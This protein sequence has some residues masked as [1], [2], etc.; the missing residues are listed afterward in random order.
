MTTSEATS[1]RPAPE[2]K[3]TS[4]PPPPEPKH[5][6]GPP[7]PDPAEKVVYCV[8]CGTP[9]FGEH[10]KLICP[11]CG[12]REDCSDLFPEPPGGQQGS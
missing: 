6:S 9:M 10:C 3:R 2:P 11:N 5:T 8:L 7:A 4:G 1:S 12:Y